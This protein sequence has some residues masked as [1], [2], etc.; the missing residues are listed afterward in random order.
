MA[1]HRSAAER[2][3]EVEGWRS[4]GCSAAA[5]AARRGYS[6]ASLSRWAAD[7]TTE[8]PEFVR[9]ELAS[10]IVRELVV[11]IGEAQVRVRRGF[12]ASLLREVVAALSTEA[13]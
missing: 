12:D 7:M 3:R 5:Y 6:Q 2:E 8:R 1:K 9:I 10:R 11:E 4:S 13:R